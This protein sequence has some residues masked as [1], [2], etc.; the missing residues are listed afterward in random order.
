MAVARR[1]TLEKS[2]ELRIRFEEFVVL[3]GLLDQSTDR[4]GD[5]GRPEDASPGERTR[6]PC[7]PV[8]KNESVGRDDP[9]IERLVIHELLD[10]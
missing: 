6:G 8:G 4:C 7:P 9:Q 5:H 2:D 3:P 10:E 1:E